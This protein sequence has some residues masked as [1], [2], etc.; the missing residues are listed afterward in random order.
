MVSSVA[1]ENINTSYLKEF[2][3]PLLGGA[4]IHPGPHSNWANR[5]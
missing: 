2:D 5:L 4:E 1:L 3:R